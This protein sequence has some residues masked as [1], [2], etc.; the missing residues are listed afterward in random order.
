MEGFWDKERYVSAHHPKLDCTCGMAD[1]WAKDPHFG[2]P[3]YRRPLCMCENS[4]KV[5]QGHQFSHANEV[6]DKADF[7]PYYTPPA[8]R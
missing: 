3:S 8:W 1:Y 6:Q 4:K 5:E 2:S 7:D